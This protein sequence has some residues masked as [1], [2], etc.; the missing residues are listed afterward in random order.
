MNPVERPNGIL[1]R[2]YLMIS[3]NL[4]VATYQA[5]LIA[6]SD[7]F[8][9]FG[10]PIT[11]GGA[12]FIVTRDMEDQSAIAYRVGVLAS[13]LKTLSKRTK[14]ASGADDRSDVEWFEPGDTIAE[15]KF[16]VD[17]GNAADAPDRS[18]YLHT[19]TK[20]VTMSA[21]H[22]F[23]PPNTNATDDGDSITRSNYLKMDNVTLRLR[24]SK[25][26]ID[27]VIYV[28]AEDSQDMLLQR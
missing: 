23:L 18:Y 19:R 11:T 3:W 10:Q 8:D 13:N 9:F 22:F 26:N 17:Q 2:E 16:L 20:R 25:K 15:V 7:A 4:C 28:L 12:I 21:S 6:V 14:I 5:P 27:R 24:Q 1:A